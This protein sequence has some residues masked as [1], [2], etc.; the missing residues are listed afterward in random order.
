MLKQ[1]LNCSHLSPLSGGLVQGFSHLSNHE[2]KVESELT[3]NLSCYT[4]SLGVTSLIIRGNK[5][6]HVKPPISHQRMK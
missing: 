4:A 1:N 3:C 6:F 5:I 2:V